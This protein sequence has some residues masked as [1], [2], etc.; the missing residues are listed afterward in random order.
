M[1]TPLQIKEK[2]RRLYP[3]FVK[4][5]LTGREIFPY[6]IPANRKLPTDLSVAKRAISQLRSEGKQSD[7]PGYRVVWE[8][9]RSRVHGRNEF[10]AA[11][12]IESQRDLLS[13]A[14]AVD[15]FKTLKT[16][17]EMLRR[18]QP[19]LN[20]W[21][22]ESTHWRELVSVA[23]CLE[24]LLDITEYLLKN[25][26]PDCFARELPLPISTKTL[27]ENKKLLASWLDLL[28]PPV[29]IDFRYDKKS[30]E[31]RYGLRY[32]RQHILT[33][34]LDPKLQTQ[35]G[36][37][38]SEISLPADSIS[39]LQPKAATVVVVENKINLLTL[40]FMPSGFAL[41]GLGKAV[42]RLR[43]I[44]WMRN[45]PILYWGDLDVEGFEILSQFRLAFPQTRS[46][47]MDSKTLD[48]CSDLTICWKGKV[49]S[50]CLEL[51]DSEQATYNDLVNNRIRLEQ[52]RIPQDLVNEAIL[53][54]SSARNGPDG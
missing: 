52:E 53:S 20:E 36:L 30:F 48:A 50:Q 26:R 14:G 54:F 25:P 19:G 7:R 13:L 34:I 38:F 21:L 33:R 27:E 6:R 29:Q 22:C 32:V 37:R 3:T 4:S 15:E 35:L 49:G 12:L 1:I 28:L 16:A 31:P 18:R 46:L 42:S 44:G 47:L 2:C 9:R 40:P 10:P 45:A 43:E 24:E 5:W 11:I 23:S 17:T 51:T 41:G 8:T 39:Q